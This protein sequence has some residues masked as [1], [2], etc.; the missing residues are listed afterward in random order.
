MHVAVSA[1][2]RRR[3]AGVEPVVVKHADERLIQ[4]ENADRQRC[5]GGD[6]PRFYCA[7]KRQVWALPGT[8]RL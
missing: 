3:E 4:C 2:D 8:K 6:E 5:G 1:R 7:G